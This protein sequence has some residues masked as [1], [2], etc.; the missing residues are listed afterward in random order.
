MDTKILRDLSYGVYIVSVK[1]GEKLSG[2]TANSIIQIT[3]DPQT[4]AVS[5]NKANYTHEIVSKTG[6]LAVS[7]IAEDSDPNIIRGFGFRSGRDCEKFEDVDY[8]IF[9]ELPV[10]KDSC[11]YFTATVKA[12]VD[13]ST[14]TIFLAELDDA[15]RLEGRT[16]M[17]YAYY[18]SVVKGKT[19]PNAPTYDAER[20]AVVAEPATTGDSAATGEGTTKKWVCPM[21]GYEYDGEVPFEDLPDSWT[22]PLCG[23]PKSMFEL[24]EI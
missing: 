22:C 4:V 12:S 14:H 21:C 16:P 5:I 3:S 2:C 24:K 6:R 8:E 20:D 11:G 1:D 10:I 9:D 19:A 15:K 13:T 17:T 18:H 7:I 23:V